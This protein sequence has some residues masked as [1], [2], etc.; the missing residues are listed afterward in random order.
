MEKYS[1]SKFQKNFNQ[2]HKRCDSTVFL[3]LKNPPLL[4]FM[5]E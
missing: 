1:N 3:N 2:M 4:L 5:N